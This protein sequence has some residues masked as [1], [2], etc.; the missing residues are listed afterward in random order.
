MDDFTLGSFPSDF[1]LLFKDCDRYQTELEQ[2]M[3]SGRCLRLKNLYSKVNGKNW[4]QREP[5][6]DSFALFETDPPRNVGK[7]Q[8]LYVFFEY[9]AR[10]KKATPRY[11]G[12][13]RDLSARLRQHG[14]GSGHNDASLAY[15]MHEYYAEQEVSRGTT[16]RNDLKL[17]QERTIQEFRVALLEVTDDYTLYFLEVYLAGKWRTRWNTFRTH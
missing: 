6:F 2:L 9:D 16:E 7:I 4:V 14:W 10:K 11:V 5:F 3:S 12:I 17:H 1:Q 13:T 15:L 8:G